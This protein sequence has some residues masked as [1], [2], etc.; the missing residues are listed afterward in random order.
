[1][2][3]VEDGEEEDFGVP[4]HNEFVPFF[5]SGGVG[6]REGTISEVIVDGWM[7]CDGFD[8]LLPV[9]RW[10]D[11]GLREKVEGVERVVFGRTLKGT[12]MT[13][14]LSTFS[15]TGKQKFTSI[16]LGSSVMDGMRSGLGGL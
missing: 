15:G 7:G 3:F 6:G 5:E 2:G 12:N 1:M 11:L 16:G 8:V 14:S 13:R 4:P 10:L 9:D